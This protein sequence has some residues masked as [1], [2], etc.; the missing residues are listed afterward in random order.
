[1]PLFSRVFRSKNIRST[2]SKQPVAHLSS[3]SVNRIP[4]ITAPRIFCGAVFS[5]EDIMDAKTALIVI[6]MQ[7]GFLN[8]ASAQCIRGAKAT[9]LACAAWA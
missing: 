2:V 9:V 1:M 7:M 3:A 8:E 4:L 6:D 5:K